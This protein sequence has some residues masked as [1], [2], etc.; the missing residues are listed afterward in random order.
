MDKILNT[1]GDT[2]TGKARE[3]L[4][5]IGTVEY[6]TPTQ[7]ELIEL[8]PSYSILVVGL[9]L[10]FDKSVLE[11]ATELKAI[12]TATTGLDHIDVEYAK[13][14]GIE[15]ISLRG[16]T[17]FLDTITGTAELAWGLMISL[18]R[19]TVPAF[20]SVKNHE[21]DRERFRGHS[22][23]G[24]TLG[25]LG[26]GRLGRMMIRWGKAFD[27]RVIA[28]DPSVDVASLGAEAVSFDDLLTQSDMLS[29][30][31]H[32]SSETENMF[33]AEALSKMK[34]SAYLINTSRGKIVNEKDL[35]TAL[36]EG[37]I[38]GYG[39]DVLANELS[40]G[41]IFDSDPLVEYAKTHA[42]CIIVPHIGGMTFESREA[43][44]IFIASKLKSFLTHGN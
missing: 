37:R 31:V 4:E 43:T 42:N 33:N 22:L 23:R 41:K 39:T 40:F 44:D 36:E 24:N 5:R 17:E 10:R 7:E 38:A 9:G 30:H 18:A 8:I 13:E 29:I 3:I 16:E 25:V 6:K 27:M 32:L 21:W 2:Y 11:K 28:S 19:H 14:R 1:I 12:A 20:E 34:K 35:L 26:A 15:V